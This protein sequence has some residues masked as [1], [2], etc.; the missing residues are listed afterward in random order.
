MKYV[1]AE[2]F[3][4]AKDGFNLR[5]ACAELLLFFNSPVRE[6]FFRKIRGLVEERAGE[7]E[8]EW[9]ANDRHFND[10]QSVIVAQELRNVTAAN[11]RHRVLFQTKVDIPL[12]AII[13]LVLMHLD[14][15]FH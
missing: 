5:P 11:S 1:Y 10:P 6:H 13:R 14:G 4:V 15:R 3:Q 7:V 2:A 12:P 9:P 8:N